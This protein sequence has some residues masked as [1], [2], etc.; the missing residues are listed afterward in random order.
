MDLAAG[1]HTFGSDSTDAS[2]GLV[3]MLE[4]ARH[5][6]SKTS[7][8]LPTRLAFHSMHCTSKGRDDGGKSQLSIAHLPGNVHAHLLIDQCGLQV[9]HQQLSSGRAFLLSN[10][11]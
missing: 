3:S 5:R 8:S 11:L 6:A 2:I 1:H 4:W 10:C 7:F 9:Q